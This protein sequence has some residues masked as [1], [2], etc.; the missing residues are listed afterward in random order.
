M[1][2]ITSRE[3]QTALGAATALGPPGGA[4]GLDFAALLDRQGQARTAVAEGRHQEAGHE[5]PASW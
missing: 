3:P 2:K 1:P 5:R 4:C